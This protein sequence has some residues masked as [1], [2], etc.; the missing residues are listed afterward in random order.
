M[1]IVDPRPPT[2]KELEVVFK[3][4]R[5]VRAI[6]KIFQ[7][8][9]SELNNLTITI[10]TIIEA[11]ETVK[12]AGSTQ[13]AIDSINRLSQDVA[14]SV[15]RPVSQTPVLDFIEGTKLPESMSGQKIEVLPWL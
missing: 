2:R 15:T 1:T 7:L 5:L 13:Q 3:N 10:E 8:I 9:P 11:V 4:P 12:A 6:E 14:L